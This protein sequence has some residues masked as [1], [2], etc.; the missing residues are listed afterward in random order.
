MGENKLLYCGVPLR[1][2]PLFDWMVGQDSYLNLLGLIT[3]AKLDPYRQKKGP[4][5]IAR[6]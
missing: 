5:R 4:G 6:A 1:G 3:V 2:A